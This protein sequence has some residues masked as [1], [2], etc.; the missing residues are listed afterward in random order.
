MSNWPQIELELECYRTKQWGKK[1]SICCNLFFHMFALLVAKWKVLLTIISKV[2]ANM[3]TYSHL[4]PLIKKK[5]LKE[6]IDVWKYGGRIY[7]AE[8]FQR[9]VRCLYWKS[10][11]IRCCSVELWFRKFLF[12]VNDENMRTNRMLSTQRAAIKIIGK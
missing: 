4:Y 7:D 6:N 8:E 10:T 2:S 12:A 9:P 1:L 3:T 5:R 11:D